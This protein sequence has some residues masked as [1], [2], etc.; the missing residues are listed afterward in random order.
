MSS[1]EHKHLKQAV[2]L[3]CV[4]TYNRGSPYP[5]ELTIVDSNN[6]PQQPYIQETI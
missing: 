6:L 3:G 2:V 1:V 5:R 4:Q